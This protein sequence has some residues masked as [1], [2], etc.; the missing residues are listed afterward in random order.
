MKNPGNKKTATA[1]AASALL[2]GASC[3]T[4]LF[5]QSD[6]V[7]MSLG[8]VV[9]TAKG[10]A[11][12]PRQVLTSVNVLTMEQI[13]NQTNYSNFELINQVP[14]VMLGE[15]AGK[16]VGFGTVSMRGF[17]TEGVLNAVKLLIDGVPS[18]ANDGNTYYIDMVPRIDMEA[19]EV[20]KGTNDPRYGLHNIAGNI[21]IVTRSGDNYT[22]S[23]L[24]AGSFGTRMLQVAKG[25]ETDS[26]SQNYALSYKTTNGYRQHMEADATNFSGKW[27]FKSGNGTSRIG[28]IVK[29]LSNNANEP[30][31][32]SQAQISAN[33]WQVAPKSVNDKDSRRASQ[34]AL[35]A[36]SDI[37]SS[38]HLQGQ[39]YW[40]QLHDDRYIKF[41]DSS[42]QEFRQ[43]R[44]QHVGAS[45]NFTRKMGKTFFGDTTIIGGV[46]TE[47]QDN[48]NFR[49]R[50]IE[51]GSTGQ[52]VVPRR[53]HQYLF[54]TVGGFV[55]AVLKPS[56]RWTITPAFRLDKVTGEGVITYDTTASSIGKWPINNYGLIKQPKLSTSFKVTDTST[57]YGN[58]GRT[59]QVGTGRAAYQ[60]SAFAVAPSIN[61]GWELGWKFKPSSMVDARFATWKQTAQSESRTLLGNPSNDTVN[62]G[63]TVR[64]GTDFELNAKPST[65][66]NI[67]AGVSLQKAEIRSTGKEVDHVPRRVYT[68]GVN[69]K[70]N[71]KW[72]AGAT[73][74]GQSSYFVDTTNPEKIGA[75]ALVN[76]TVGYKI[77]ATMDVD[78]QIRNLTNRMYQYSYDNVYA[79]S[80]GN[81]YAANMPRSF[82]LALS[83]KL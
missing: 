43:L 82:Y 49:E 8:E 18:N 57:V 46:D 29:H 60:T 59:F 45:V 77:S 74:T 76:T 53:N 38:T 48:I 37:D 27:F 72:R 7:V 30:G 64:T 81:F 21:N 66:T 34:V 83:M 54:N 41:A 20:V 31:Y 1:V 50:P 36:E 71:D 23:K 26:V 22:E 17:N 33:P 3:P 15:Y 6:N 35:Q 75:Y 80:P 32:L 9:V 28:L 16:G 65:T 40:N 73:V 10:G 44:E 25:I 24:T 19:V 12:S 55:Q 68:F 78:F 62:L 69:E 67:W 70:F 11:L 5:A 56:N 2:F 47:R 63:Q 14:G 13:E 42:R 51:I 4:A 52:S 61:E 58:W 39:V 79:G